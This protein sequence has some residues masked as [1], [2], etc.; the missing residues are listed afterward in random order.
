MGSG[1]LQ[2]DV[3]EKFGVVQGSE[4]VQP[5][6]HCNSTGEVYQRTAAV[7]WQIEVALM[8]ASSQVVERARIA[9]DD[10]PD[11]FQ[12]ECLVYL[13]REFCR[14]GD[15]R[16]VNDLSAILIDR[17]KNMIYG[18]LQVLGQQGVEDAFNDVILDLFA[19]ILDLS[20]DRGDFLQVRFGL[21]LQRLIIGVYNRHIRRIKTSQ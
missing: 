5:L 4:Q 15:E 11:Y 1:A 8:L 9:D 20:S 10:S 18:R 2:S 16:L 7:H 6:T 17:C 21:V 14:R 19:P 12:E 3:D 13:I